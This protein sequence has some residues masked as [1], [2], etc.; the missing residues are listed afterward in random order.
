[1]PHAFNDTSRTAQGEAAPHTWILAQLKV[2]AGHQTARPCHGLGTAGLLQ[3]YVTTQQGLQ[4]HGL[5]LNC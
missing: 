2:E 4:M 3:G 1:M 5:G